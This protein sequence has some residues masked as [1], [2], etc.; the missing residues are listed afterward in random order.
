MSD[1]DDSDYKPEVPE[2]P[3]P[4]AGAL[5]P[6]VPHL[7]VVAPTQVESPAVHA[8][9]VGGFAIKG[10]QEH[11]A[12]HAQLF[13]KQLIP[14]MQ[15]SV[16][17]WKL[18]TCKKYYWIMD[19]MVRIRNG[20]TAA[21][22]RATYAQAYK[23]RKSY[24][25]VN[26]GVGGFIIVDRPDN[27]FGLNGDGDD[28]DGDVESVVILTYFEAAYSNINKCHLPDHTKG[29]TLYA[30]VCQVYSNIARNITKLYTETCPICIC[31]EVQNKPP[32]GVRPILTFGFRTR[33][34]V[35]IID[36]QILPNGEFKYLLNYIDHG[37]LVGNVDIFYVAKS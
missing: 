34:Q 15:K 20:E 3:T 33:G 18:G 2:V 5:I 16:P 27:V 36:F 1:Q 26:N 28:I 19:A 12:A 17:S 30:R 35:D 22:V 13:Y 37:I 11:N 23:W 29:R 24:V 4:V 6:N 21:Q 25:L 31:R 9:L 10:V 14:M 32:A 7:P 8:F